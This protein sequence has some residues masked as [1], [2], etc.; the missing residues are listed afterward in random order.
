MTM[1]EIKKFPEH[2]EDL[3]FKKD[4]EHKAYDENNKTWHDVY[5]SNESIVHF[6][7]LGRV[8]VVQINNDVNKI[9]IFWP[10]QTRSG[11]YTL[12]DNKQI[13]TMIEMVEALSKKENKND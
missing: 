3:I 8:R 2:F 11:N 4:K 9:N 12:Y 13:Q 7:C 6:G 1:Q 10:L 5:C